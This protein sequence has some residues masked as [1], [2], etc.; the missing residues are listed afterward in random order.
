MTLIQKI[1]I[2]LKKRYNLY[3]IISPKTLRGNLNPVVLISLMIFF[4]GVFFISSNFINKKNKV[5]KIINQ[6]MKLEY[7]ELLK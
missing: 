5:I 3:S 1:I 4:S 6:G 7:F 2:F